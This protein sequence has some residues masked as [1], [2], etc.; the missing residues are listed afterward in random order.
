VAGDE[1]MKPSVEVGGS[2]EKMR[3]VI[4]GQVISNQ[5]VTSDKRRVEDRKS[6]QLAL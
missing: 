2:R 1:G 6:N 3:K 5:K 4:S